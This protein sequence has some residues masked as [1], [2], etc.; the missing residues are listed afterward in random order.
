MCNCQ[1]NI[2]KGSYTWAI[3]HFNTWLLKIFI[4]VCC[5]NT[6]LFFDQNYFPTSFYLEYPENI[7]YYYYYYSELFNVWHCLSQL[8][9]FVYQ[10]VLIHE[11]FTPHC[12]LHAVF[13]L[14]GDDQLCTINHHL[15]NI[16]LIYPDHINLFMSG[17]CSVRI[18]IPIMFHIFY[19]PVLWVYIPFSIVQSVDWEYLLVVWVKCVGCEKL[20]LNWKTYYYSNYTWNLQTK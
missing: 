3:K 13:L 12:V 6:R 18:L 17:D 10:T 16:L 15:Y 14:F 7:Y 4:V 9:T 1:K 2:C 19:I 11:S 20:V 8:S 5:E